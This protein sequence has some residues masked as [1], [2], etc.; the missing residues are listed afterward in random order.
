MFESELQGT[1]IVKTP[2]HP[3]HNLIQPEVGFDTIIAVHTT[4]ELYFY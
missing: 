1:T 3:Q 2:T 4:Q